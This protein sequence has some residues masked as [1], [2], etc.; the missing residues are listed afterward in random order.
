MSKK[1]AEQKKFIYNAYGKEPAT[2]DELAHCVIATINAQK[3]T[4]HYGKGTDSY[5]VVG[6]AWQINKSSEVS[7]SHSHPVDGM[8]NWSRRDDKLP[9]GYPGW[10]G[11]VWIR[12]NEDCKQWGSTPF[13]RTL[14]HTGT[15]G[16][17]GYDGPWEDISNYRYR[18]YGH[19]RSKDMYP[20]INCYS[21]D[22][23]FYDMDWPLLQ[24]FYEEEEMVAKLKNLNPILAA[25]HR[26]EWN[27]PV[28]VAADEAF[29]QE[30][31]KMEQNG[32][33]NY[34]LA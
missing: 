8:G 15:G 2:L 11:R 12:Y 17:G 33:L 4:D 19:K 16:G 34:T 22:Y 7:N 6:F 29:K 10:S 20:T 27:D 26:F 24:R 13:S 28:V 1:L 21:W 32:R 30:C 14:T 5:N 3:N 18:R 25:R 9:T 31:I 23:R